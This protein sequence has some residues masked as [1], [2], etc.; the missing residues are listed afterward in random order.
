M[1]SFTP[2]PAPASRS[3]HAATERSFASQLDEGHFFPAQV[4]RVEHHPGALLHHARHADPHAL[5]LGEGQP[6]RA[7]R[8]LRRAHHRF[9][10]LG[11]LAREQPVLL[12]PEHVTDG[13]DHR[14]AHVGAAKVDAQ[15]QLVTKLHPLRF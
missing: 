11:R 6:C 15:V 7:A 10:H 1:R 13:I 9:R 4:G 3:P 12:L 8:R 5:H 14:G 2:R